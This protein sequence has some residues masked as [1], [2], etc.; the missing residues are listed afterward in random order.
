MWIYNLQYIAFQ[1]LRLVYLLVPVDH[2]SWMQV[3]DGFEELV[4]HITF[5]DVFE[6]CA[7]LYHRVQVGV[8]AKEQFS[9]TYFFL[10]KSRWNLQNNIT[11]V[12]SKQDF[13]S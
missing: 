6:Q 5:V 2:T 9:K 10:L 7:F 8:C 11:D 12:V 1:T 13:T 4:H 3:F